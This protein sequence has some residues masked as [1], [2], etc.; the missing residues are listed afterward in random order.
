MQPV[1][2]PSWRWFLTRRV[3]LVG[4]AA[5]FA[6]LF[7]VGLMTDS[8]DDPEERDRRSAL[9]GEEVGRDL[10]LSWRT[11]FAPAPPDISAEC[12]REA[13]DAIVAD[14]DIVGEDF[15]AACVDAYREGYEGYEP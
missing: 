4:A 12:S 15:L 6:G 14:A 3:V 9:I 5:V 11:Y 10:N 13:D 2:E 7:I 8:P 1:S